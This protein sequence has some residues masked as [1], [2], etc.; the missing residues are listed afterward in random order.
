M[1]A[2]QSVAGVYTG[3]LSCGDQMIKGVN[4][5]RGNPEMHSR[6]LRSQLIAQIL[7]AKSQLN[8]YPV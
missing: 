5:K 4:L 2:L 6:K 8:S 7:K 3:V 1:A